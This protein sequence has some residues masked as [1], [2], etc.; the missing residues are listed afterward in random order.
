MTLVKY[1]DENWIEN[2][3]IAWQRA[4]EAFDIDFN[5]PESHIPSLMSQRVA[6]KLVCK[7]TCYL[8]IRKIQ[9]NPSQAIYMF[10]RNYLPKISM[11]MVE[12]Y[13]ENRDVDGFLYLSYSRENTFG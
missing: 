11:N 13:Q 1:C 6:L 5:I 10:V 7:H 9:L 3:D 8:I 2:H 4:R 12:I